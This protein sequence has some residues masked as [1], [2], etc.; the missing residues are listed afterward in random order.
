MLRMY[1]VQHWFNL[2]DQACE[3]A[4][5]D[6]MALRR[7]VSIDLGH[8]R[9]PDGTTL[10][11]F[12]RLLDKHELGKQLFATVGQV[13]QAQGMKVGAGT[14]QLLGVSSNPGR[15]RSVDFVYTFLCLRESRAPTVPAG[16][17]STSELHPK[18]G[19]ILRVY[20]I[21]PPTQT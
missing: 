20:P 18:W 8:E 14:V 6:S 19:R 16:L 1:F 10:L 5:L 9:V 13:L 17:I 2:A 21:T 15:F 4:L 3:E 12:R 11:K 7:F